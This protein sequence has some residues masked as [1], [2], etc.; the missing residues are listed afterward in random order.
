[1]SKKD[2]QK[3]ETTEIVP[4]ES[5][6]MV[7][8]AAEIDF[9]AYAGYG[10]EGA[11][12]DSYAIPF[13]VC[14]HPLSPIV[15][16]K[17]APGAEGG[18]IYNTITSGVYDSVE[19]IPCA[20]QRRFIRW[21]PRSL[22]GGFKGEYLPH[23]VEGGN[24]VGMLRH[25]NGYFMDVP[26]GANPLDDKGK[27]L[28]D[29]LKD[30]RSHFVLYKDTD[31]TWKPACISMAST[32]IKRSKRW[33]SLISGIELTTPGGKRYSPPSFSQV[34]TMTTEQEENNEGTWWSWVIRH[35]GS[36][37]DAF[38]FEKAK[39]FHDQVLQGQ[40]AVNRE[41]DETETSGSHSNEGAF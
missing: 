14:L 3:I 10:T 17:L 15:A 39:A 35:T 9:S 2:E 29:Q 7:Q 20:Y 38:T 27:P 32:Q 31:G 30:T 26:V 22:G 6:S 8:P 1:M 34:Y 25:K 33:M 21:A 23:E 24:L 4:A 5:T 12:S 37:P 18:K 16:K 19:V 13:L 11:D 28:Y 36:V 41:S 40:V